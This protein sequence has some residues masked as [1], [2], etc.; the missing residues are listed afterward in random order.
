M[1][2]AL[3]ISVAA[4]LVMAPLNVMAQGTQK[5]K[6]MSASGTVTAVSATSLTIKAKSDEWTFTVGDDTKVTGT[7]ASR[8]TEELKAEKKP[9]VITEYVKVGDP[10]TVR[11][12]EVDKAKHA[13]EI[14]LQTPVKK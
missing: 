8:K 7:G 10:I 11:Y 13:S 9:A 5:P 14:R 12:H 3:L 2:R 1:K 6:T 4:L